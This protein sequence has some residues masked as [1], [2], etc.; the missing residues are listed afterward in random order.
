MDGP[1][2]TTPRTDPNKKPF[3][4]G[5]SNPKAS[6]SP[7]L[8]GPSG[9]GNTRGSGEDAEPSVKGNPRA[10]RHQE[11]SIGRGN[12][13]TSDHTG[14]SGREKASHRA[15]PSRRS[16]TLGGGSGWGIPSNKCT[17]PTPKPNGKAVIG[18]ARFP[19]DNTN[20]K[21]TSSQL[22]SLMDLDTSRFDGFEGN[23][24]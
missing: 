10:A 11:G 7:T 23:L 4:K 13:R 20:R 24:V 6:P 18:P 21:R 9:T 8:P 5:N 12:P 15:S 2:T 19:N 3:G 16:T 14:T 1:S 22:C 17:A